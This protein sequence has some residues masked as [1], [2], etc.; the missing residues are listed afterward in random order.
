MPDQQS[1]EPHLQTS[2]FS[3]LPLPSKHTAA[4]LQVLE[5]DAQTSPTVDVHAELPQTQGDGL[6]PWAQAGPVKDPTTKLL[7]VLHW[8]PGP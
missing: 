4:W 1:T 8:L 3:E 2:S 7:E 6:S 5:R